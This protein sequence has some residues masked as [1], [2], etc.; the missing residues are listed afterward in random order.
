MKKTIIIDN[1]EIYSNKFCK[2]IEDSN[3]SVGY[4]F[5]SSKHAL[6]YL[7]NNFVEI[8]F[9]D[10]YM[11]ES[12]GIELVKKI[13]KTNSSCKVV[14]LSMYT[15]K[16]IVSKDLLRKIDGYIPS[17][18][19]NTEIKEAISVS[20]YNNKNK[21]AK[22]ERKE[23]IKNEILK[24]YKITKREKE[25]IYHVLNQKSSIEIAKELLISKRTVDVHRRNIIGKFKV[26][27]TI[28]IAIKLLE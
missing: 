24:K 7:K 20:F 5:Q 25:I 2:L 8:V 3:C 26:K 17:S 16:N 9:C 27:N 4:I 21:I 14:F 13:K 15:A 11:P 1:H 10:I 22:G 23:L 19:T 12:H 6:E 28:G 18:Y